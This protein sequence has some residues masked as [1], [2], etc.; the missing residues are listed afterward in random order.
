MIS[1]S[2]EN[3]TTSIIVIYVPIHSSEDEVINKF[4]DELRRAIE[5]IPYHNVLMIIGDCYT[6]IIEYDGHFIHYHEINTNGVVLL[7]IINEKQLVITKP[8]FKR[9]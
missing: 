4:Y 8:F 5:T 6:R 7:D 2:H 1:T 9:S 3:P